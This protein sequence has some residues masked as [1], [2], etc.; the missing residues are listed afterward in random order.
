MKI[1]LKEKV[2]ALNAFLE[3]LE[4]SHTSKVIPQ[5]KG[6]EKQNKNQTQQRN[7]QEGYTQ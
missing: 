6:I 4:R 1:M 5:P 2:I 7:N 3:K